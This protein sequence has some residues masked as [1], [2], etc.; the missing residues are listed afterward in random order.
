MS[1]RPLIGRSTAHVS[2]LGLTAQ[3]LEPQSRFSG[4]AGDISRAVA[5]AW[6]NYSQNGGDTLCVMMSIV[7]STLHI[8]G[9]PHDETD[10]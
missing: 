9:I 4:C 7:R 1:P 3:S 10:E 2:R 6:Y 8:I 5:P